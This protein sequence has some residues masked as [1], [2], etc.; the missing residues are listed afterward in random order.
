[1][2]TM[3]IEVDSSERQKKRVIES[4]RLVLQKK[5]MI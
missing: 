3:K 5:G 2:A 4:F 1:M